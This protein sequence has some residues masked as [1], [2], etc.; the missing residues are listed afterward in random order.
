[1]P[2]E[3]I[4]WKVA[5]LTAAKLA[6]SPFNEALRD[7]PRALALGA[8]FPDALFYLTGPRDP[9]LD[10]LPRI[11]H[12][13]RGEDTFEL[14]RIQAERVRR[15]PAHL[16]ARAF[17]VGL[18]SHVFTDAVMHPFVYHHTGSYETETLAKTRHRL[19]ETTMDLA[20]LKD[21]EELK[22][23]SLADILAGPDARVEDLVD[24]EALARLGGMDADTLRN[25]LRRAL[26]GF[27]RLQ[28]L[29]RNRLWA[30]LAFGLR[31]VLPAR[32]RTVAALFY[33]P[34]LMRMAPLL[35]GR[36]EYL[37]PVTGQ[38]VR[39]SL[40]RLMEEA[41]ERAAGFCRDLAPALDNKAPLDVPGPGPGLGS[42][43][44]GVGARQGRFFA[45][46]F[47]LPV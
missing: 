34:R 21:M 9:R 35:Q 10:E 38:F 42:G 26:A 1:M 20:V 37:H 46:T 36:L 47:L 17:L 40:E 4:H 18:V 32:A 13:G 44:P 7:H 16:P 41:A 25:G 31:K 29:F 19:L 6:D 5:G 2:K 24:I 45:D 12:G 39:T 30:G 15:D 8:V 11:L 33:A 22:R 23:Y 43:L 3:I 14:L 28:A 27:T